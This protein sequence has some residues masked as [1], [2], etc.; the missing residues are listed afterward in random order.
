LSRR[1]PQAFTRTSTSR[2]SSKLTTKAA[3]QRENSRRP[4]ANLIAAAPAL[5]EAALLVIERWSQGDLADAVRM[6]DSAVAEAT[7]GAT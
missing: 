1:T 5:L 3:W 2:K 4:N 6:L 7:G